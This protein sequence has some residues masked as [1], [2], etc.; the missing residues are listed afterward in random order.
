MTVHEEYVAWAEGEE[1]QRLHDGSGIY[2][3]KAQEEYL[4]NRLWKAFMAGASAGARVAKKEVAD[5]FN[6]LIAGS[7]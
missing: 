7:L 5:R 2:L 3:P 4:R 6:R 1:G